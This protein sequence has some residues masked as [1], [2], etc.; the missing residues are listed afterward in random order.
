[1]EK[2]TVLFICSFNSVRSRIAEGL[3]RA[4][5][6]NRYTVLS[7]GI[8]PASLNPYAA[9][10]MREKGIDI[11]QQQPI[12]VLELRGMRFDY[13]IT[14]CDHVPRANIPLPEGKKTIHHGFISPCEVRENREDV[15]ADFRKLRDRIDVYLTEIFPDCPQIQLKIV[16]PV[17]S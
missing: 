4:R 5:C 3:L 12:S 8:A 14:L 15:L 13:V 10:V 17:L 6:G 16:E 7:A 11:T 9:A 1:M 2:E